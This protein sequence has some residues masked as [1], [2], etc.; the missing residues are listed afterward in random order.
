MGLICLR[1]SHFSYI[2]NTDFYEITSCLSLPYHFTF[3]MTESVKE[4]SFN[5]SAAYLVPV[6]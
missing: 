1:W 5:E 2:K 3:S 6:V 4:N